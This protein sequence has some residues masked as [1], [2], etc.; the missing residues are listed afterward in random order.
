MQFSRLQG[1]K[2]HHKGID[3][4]ISR[5]TYAQLQTLVL[6][7]SWGQ[8]PE[9]RCSKTPCMILCHACFQVLCMLSSRESDKHIWRPQLAQAL[10]LNAS[11]SKAGHENLDSATPAMNFGGKALYRRAQ[12][13]LE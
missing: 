8:T 5:Q 13:R 3:S 9:N 4:G 10:V 7:G 6:E 2:G 12:A 11:N 1:F